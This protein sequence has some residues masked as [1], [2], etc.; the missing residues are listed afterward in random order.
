MAVLYG[1]LCLLLYGKYMQDK[2]ILCEDI[3]MGQLGSHTNSVC[4]ECA[5][6]NFWM[7]KLRISSWCWWGLTIG[8]QSFQWRQCL[9]RLIPGVFFISLVVFHSSGNVI[10][11]TVAFWELCCDSPYVGFYPCTQEL[12]IST[13]VL[14]ILYILEQSQVNTISKTTIT[15]SRSQHN[16]I[17]YQLLHSNLLLWFTTTSSDS[18]ASC[19]SAL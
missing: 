18:H 9:L 3:Y 16:M 11:L 12:Y 14:V 6:R 19:L 13:T 17:Y 7:V 1:T 2:A 5:G 10:C 8:K 4:W 15:H